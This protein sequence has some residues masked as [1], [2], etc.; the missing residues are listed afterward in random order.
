MTGKGPLRWLVSLWMC[1]LNLFNLGK[2]DRPENSRSVV[3]NIPGITL[4]S[5]SVTGSVN[6]VSMPIL[7][8]KLGSTSGTIWAFSKAAVTLSK[9][10]GK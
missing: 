4:T 7:G 10:V 5:L 8:L 1:R 6:S 3:S 2:Y 9:Q